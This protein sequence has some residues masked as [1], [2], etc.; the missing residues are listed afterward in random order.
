MADAL[1]ANEISSVREDVL[2]DVELP[3]K[4]LSRSGS[5]LLL[6]PVLAFHYL[7]F[8]QLLESLICSMEMEGYNT[9]AALLK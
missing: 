1:Q 9:R 8:K 3:P 7:R 4:V 6:E 2:H 5:G